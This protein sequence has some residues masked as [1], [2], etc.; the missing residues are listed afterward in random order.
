MIFA[1]PAEKQYLCSKNCDM[2]RLLMLCAICL[3][4]VGVCSCNVTRTITT[5]AECEKKGDSVQV[6]KSQTVETY[7]ARSN[8]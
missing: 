8:Q 2:K 5:H 7:D 3:A 6:I 4:L 1:H